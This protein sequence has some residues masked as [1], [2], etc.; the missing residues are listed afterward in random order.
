MQS[1]TLKR[2][3]KFVVDVAALCSAW[4][5]GK[6][7]QSEV[8]PALGV[9]RWAEGFTHVPS[10]GSVIA[11]WC[12]LALWA[13]AYRSGWA[14][15]RW[16]KFVNSVHI[17]MAFGFAIIIAS[18][19]F[20]DSAG[21]HSRS[22]AIFVTP[23]SFLL[24]NLARLGFSA[25]MTH[26]P[27]HWG[28]K[29]GIAVLGYG[30]GAVSMLEYL[31]TT[32]RKLVRGLIVPEGRSSKDLIRSTSVLGTT[33]ELAQLINRERLNRIV[34]MM[35]GSLSDSE[36]EECSDVSTRMGVTVSC[37]VSAPAPVRNLTYSVFNG[38]PLVEVH[39]VSFARSDLLLKRMFDIAGSFTSL[40]LLAP[41]MAVIAFLVKATSDGPIFFTAPR[42]GRGG[43]YFTFLKFRTMYS[44]TNRTELVRQNEKD[45]HLFKIRNDPRV[46]PLG[47]I[48]R[49][50]SLDELPQLINVLLGDMSLVGPRPLPIED[51]EPDG[52]SQKF[53]IWSAQRASVPPGIT[54]LWQI[55][56]RSE[57][58]FSDLVKYDL[59][60]VHNWSFA[61]DLKILLSTPTFVLTGKGAF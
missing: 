47:R 54:G 53:A 59:E 11:V 44:N 18:F 48:L 21:G 3:L 28:S 31:Q 61:F 58:P 50:Y 25:V 29:N 39:P 52:M 14:S 12:L 32:D 55:R 19:F 10:L 41:L 16:A 8:L 51:L 36:V 17:S 40:V 15:D 38:I 57:L 46:T 26:L 2:N 45:G 6:V 42:V 24:V 43:R 49:R 4:R 34:M 9:V 30:E 60:Y 5:L 23:L 37:A 7:L 22:V 33:K 1:E 56:G 35:N 13:G 27:S 20:I